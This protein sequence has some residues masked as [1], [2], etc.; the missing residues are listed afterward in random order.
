V[1]RRD[2]DAE[3]LEAGKVWGGGTYPAD[4]GVGERCKLPQRGPGRSPGRKRILMHLEP[5]YFKEFSLGDI[6]LPFITLLSPLLY[7]FPYLPFPPFLS[8]SPN[9]FLRSFLFLACMKQP[10]K[11]LL[12]VWGA[13]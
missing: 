4:E 8:P 5:V 1:R 9:P 10:S 3:S 12:G 11:I 13:L 7:F 6:A 2:R